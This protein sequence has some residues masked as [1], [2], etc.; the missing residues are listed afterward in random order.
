MRL[1]T[2]FPERTPANNPIRAT[3]EPGSS[4]ANSTIFPLFVVSYRCCGDIRVSVKSVYEKANVPF[5][6]LLVV[7]KMV[8]TGGELTSN[9]LQR[10]A[11]TKPISTLRVRCRRLLDVHILVEQE[12]P[13]S[14]RGSKP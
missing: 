4:Q 10:V 5:G 8:E 1:E 6:T 13:S 3:F 12:D 11:A 7:C 9:I 14:V 2:G